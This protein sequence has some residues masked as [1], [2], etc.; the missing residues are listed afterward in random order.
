M[1][2]GDTFSG[3]AGNYYNRLIE[4]FRQIDGGDRS[5]GLPPYNGGLFAEEA[6]P[7][8]AKVRL[9]DSEVAPVVFGLSHFGH[10]GHGRAKFVNYRDMSVQ[11]LGSIYE[12][13]LEREPVRDPAGNVSIQL[14]R[15][16]RKDSGSFYTSQELVD[17]IVEQTLKPLAEERLRAFEAKAEEL[18]SDRRPKADRLADLVQI[19]PAEAVLDLKV[20]DP[21]MGSGHFLVT[22]VDFLSDYVA[23]LIEYVPAVPAWLEEPY[24]SP[25]VGRIARIRQGILHRAAE[26]EWVIDEAQLTD[27][28]I[29]RRMVLKRCI[30]GVDKNR[31]T[32]ELAKVSLWLHSFT[33][34]APLS[35]LDHHL[36]CGDSLVGLRVGDG[37][38]ELRRLGGLIASSAIQGAENAVAGMELIEEMSD[39]DVSEVRESARLFEGVDQA[40]SE[41]RRVLD[42]LCSLRWLTAGMKKRQ[43]NEFETRGLLEV[44]GAYPAKA[45]SLLAEGPEAI[46]ATS[47]GSDDA[48]LSRFGEL[49]RDARALAE[50]ETFLHWE[51]A[52]PGVWR[53]WQRRSPEGGFD[54][55]IGNP[56]WDRIKLQE[57]EWFATRDPELA[58]APTAAQRR[59]GIKK[60][61]DRGEPLAAAFDEAKQRADSLLTLFRTSG[62]YPLLGRG[63]INLYSLFVER[64]LNVL[65]PGGLVGLLVPSGIYADKTAAPFFQSVSTSGR[66]AGLFDFENRRLGTGLPPFFPDVHRSFK[67][68]ALILGG[69]ERTFSET[70]CGFFL[71]SSGDLSDPERCFPLSP[72][73]FT[74][75]NPNTGT[76]PVFRTR[77]DAEITRG[78]YERHPVLV[79][80]SSGV[81]RRAWPVRY[82]TMFHMTND[83][84]LFR[85]AAELEAAGCYPIAGNRWKRGEEEW[86]PLYEGKMVQA[87]DHRAA[88]VV[89]NPENLNRPA[90]PREATLAEHADPDWSPD[91]QFWVAADDVEW[92]EGLDWAVGFKDV[93]APTNVRTMIAAIVPRSGVGNTL[94]LLMPSDVGSTGSN[95]EALCLLAAN[96]N[97]FVFDFVARQ[98]VQGQHLNWFIVE[99]LP[100]IA[101]TDYEGRFGKNT[102]RD[103]V[104]DHVLR[105]TYT[106]HDMEPF[107]NDLGYD[108]PPFAWDDE[109][110]RHLKARLDALYFLLYGRSRDE[111]EHVLG[112]FPIVRRQDEAEFGRYRT[113]EIVLA[114]MSAL[115]VGDTATVVAL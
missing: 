43:R 109:E 60:L 63:D 51:V 87:F 93:T 8:L 78:I 20:L 71:D 11:Q 70:P 57:V 55:V 21:A 65:K 98:K 18:K 52:F 100:V 84:H 2:E 114:Y 99:Q 42:F 96:F 58:R 10:K 34:G 54:A 90:Q 86:L 89:V 97:S 45:Y 32:V 62:D 108:G 105:L 7:L 68:S 3:T 24:E 82:N 33:V 59:I 103:L 92:S 101:E 111:A 113:S 40:T 64:T 6:A 9:A 47:A 106:A 37:T 49:W 74:R 50:R 15:F 26:S 73:D 75:V 12:R 80:R 14:N 27:Q 22:A 13:L 5:I 41:L 1:A 77:R 85:A 81:E 107:A 112:T 76:A 66:V 19:D 94:P 28:A 53:Y 23:E 61:R 16:A 4:L 17:L 44:I 79:D 30:Y 110:R 72:T 115:E 56:P 25:L 35:F 104:C 67:F 91:P 39:A 88:S 83:S 69:V 38:D 102:A 31:L 36:R 46:D 48:G 95:A 29:I